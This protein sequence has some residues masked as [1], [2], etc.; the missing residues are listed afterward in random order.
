MQALSFAVHIP[1]VCFG[2]AFPSMVLLR[3]VALPA[4]RRRDLPHARQAL[5]EGD[6]RPVRRRRRDRD[7]P[8]LRDGPAVAELHGHVRRRLRAGLR[9]GGLLVLRRGD[10]HRDLRLRLGPHVAARALPV[11]HAGR[12]R[13]PHRLA[14]RDRGQRVDEPPVR[15]SGW[16]TASAVDV[17]PWEALF[18]NGHLWPE[19]AH[20]YLAGFIVA[21]FLVAAAYA[22]GL[23]EGQA[24]PLRADRAGG[25][26]HDRGAR[27]AGPA[28]RRRLD[29]AARGRGPAHQ[30]RGVRGARPRRRSGATVHL[31]GWYE[32]GEV[33]GGI[34]IPKAAVAARRRTTRTPRSRASTPSP[35]EDRPPVNVVRFAFQTMVGIGTLLAALSVVHLVTLVPAP[36]V[37]CESR[38]FLRAV[39][40]AGPL[41]VV[42]LIA[43]WVTTEVGPPA[44]GRLRRDAHVRGRHRGRRHPRRLRHAGRRLRRAR[45][46]RSRGSCGGCAQRRS[47]TAGRA[48]AD[49]GGPWTLADVP[50]VLILVGIAA[51]VV[52]AGAD[53][54]A[55]LGTSSPGRAARAAGSRLHLP[56][57]GARVGGQ[58]RLA[59]LRARGHV[60]G[61]SRRVRLDRLDA[62]RAALHRRGGDHPARNRLR[63]AQR[64]RR[65]IARRRASTGFVFG[66]VLDP[67]PVRAGRGDRRRSRPAASRSATPRATSSRAG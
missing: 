16:R 43:G 60:D 42:A 19:L 27:R 65:R 67:H 29:R 41:S 52:F 37:A 1:L 28:R 32:D 31:L 46:S 13:G 44:V 25:P 35:P 57:D 9:P 12:R 21:G 59:D 38:W 11:R 33:K 50:A 4:D 10:L 7:D 55:G 63:P 64:Q 15:A 20:M 45:R 56:R 30:A 51:Y 2:I 62:R 22:V 23:A 3:R 58:P 26:A 61:L 49:P 66:A 18:G 24:R 48:A 6:D 40:A 54:G 8:L 5:V 53:F 36:A 14:V 17:E 39:V 47:T 34:A